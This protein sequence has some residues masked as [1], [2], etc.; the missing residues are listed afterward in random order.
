MRAKIQVVIRVKLR[1]TTIL[2]PQVPHTVVIGVVDIEQ[3]LVKE[4][5]SFIREKRGKQPKTSLL[6]MVTCKRRF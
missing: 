4:V 1:K 2:S 3:L 6:V 5:I